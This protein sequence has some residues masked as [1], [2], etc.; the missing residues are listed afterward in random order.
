MGC[1]AGVS[2]A[3]ERFETRVADHVVKV[4]GTA[5]VCGFYCVPSQYTN[6]KKLEKLLTLMQH[7]RCIQQQS[8]KNTIHYGDSCPTRYNT[9]TIA[10]WCGRV[11]PVIRQISARRAHHPQRYLSAR[12][13]DELEHSSFLQRPAG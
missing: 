11:R 12:S 13:E 6:A 2:Q 4:I 5:S 3:I 10:Q 8:S 7:S 9:L 1:V